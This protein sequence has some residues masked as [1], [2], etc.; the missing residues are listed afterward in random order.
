MSG[1]VGNPLS[2]MVGTGGET[3]ICTL[4]GALGQRSTLQ[5][6]VGDKANVTVLPAK[7]ENGK[8]TTVLQVLNNHAVVTA[9]EIGDGCTVPVGH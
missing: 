9:A 1:R 7:D 8:V 5:T 6:A 3:T 4:V 2:T